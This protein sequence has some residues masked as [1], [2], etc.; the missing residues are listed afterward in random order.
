MDPQNSAQGEA[1]GDFFFVSGGDVSTSGSGTT[2][3]FCGAWVLSEGRSS[4]G[5]QLFP[6]GSNDEHFREHWNSSIVQ[7]FFKTTLLGGT[8]HPRTC[9]CQAENR[10]LSDFG[11]IKVPMSGSKCVS[12]DI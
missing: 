9:V 11:R 2:A 3:D 6:G 5:P 1:Y 10:I 7:R 4:M 8:G 12:R